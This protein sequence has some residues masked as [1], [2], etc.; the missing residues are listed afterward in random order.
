MQAFLSFL[1]LFIL[2]LASFYKMV[3]ATFDDGDYQSVSTFFVY[4]MQSTRN[5]IGDIAV[6]SYKY[7]HDQEGKGK[8]N[9]LFASGMIIVIWLIFYIIN[10]LVLLVC[11]MNF[12]IAIV[13]ETYEKVLDMHIVNIYTHRAFLNQ[14]FITTFGEEIFDEQFSIILLVRAFES[15]KDQ[16][17]MELM[18]GTNKA[19]TYSLDNVEHENAKKLEMI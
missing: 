14:E 11:L 18:K 8:P 3:G 19:L 15:T 2:T 7:W 12:L 10:V 13:S 17:V 4:L 1:F 9:N 16:T 6:P 5:S